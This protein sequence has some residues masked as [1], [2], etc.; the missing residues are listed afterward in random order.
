MIRPVMT[1][2]GATLA[3]RGFGFLRDIA[4]AGLFGA[5][6]RADAFL[7]AFQI[8]NLARRMLAEGALNAALVP[9]YLQSKT[10]QGEPAAHRLIGR[11]AGTLTLALSALALLLT[12]A[13]PFLILL[14]APGFEMRGERHALAVAWARLML[15]YLV[16]AGPAAIVMG[17]LNAHARFAAAA[18]I[19]ALFNL[20]VLLALLAVTAFRGGDSDASGDVLAGSVAFAGLCQLVLLLIA[21]RRAGLSLPRLSIGFDPEIR[22]FIRRAIPG[23]IANASSQF[24][25]MAG[26]MAASTSAGAISW[27]VYAQRLIELPLGLVGAGVATVLLPALSSARQA[28]DSRASAAARSQALELALGLSLPAAIALAILSGPIVRTLFER[29][30]FSPADSM[31]TAAAMSLLAFG[32]PGQVLFRTFS[33]SFF[34][35]GDTKTPMLAGLF[36]LGVAACGS[37]A[38]MPLI[39]HAGVALAIAASGWASTAALARPMRRH[40]GF[41]LDSATPRRLALIVLAASLMGAAIHLL[42]LPLQSWFAAGA[43][44]LTKFAGL[45]LLVGSGL[46]LYALSLVAFG[47]L[48]RRG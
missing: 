31:A 16:F 32:L 48:R 29:G 19:G 17:L 39:G 18:S 25:L 15:P 3:S 8:A 13:M 47:I 5:G 1:I 21:V 35:R 22:A 14:L 45:G 7:A 11:V 40:G 2:G 41:A 24:T 43:G 38:L 10:E 12:L 37:F 30:A 27:L 28:N 26:I 34:A 36:G 46:G 23:A 20:V 42:A 4:I 9:L 6:A 44:T 33:Q